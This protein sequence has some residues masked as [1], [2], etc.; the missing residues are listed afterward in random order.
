MEKIVI[1]SGEVGKLEQLAGKPQALVQLIAKNYDHPGLESLAAVLTQHGAAVAELDMSLAFPHHPY[2][3]D[4]RAFDFAEAC[5]NL[6]SLTVG[7][8]HLNETVLLHPALERV[9]LDDCWLYTSDPLR[10]GYPDS[11][12]SKV[13]R[14]DL[15]EVNWG[16][17]E[18]D[19]LGHLAF[20]PDS[21][22]QEF[23][24]YGDEDNMEI[25]PE[26]ITFDGCPHLNDVG[27]HVCGGWFVEFKGDLPALSD[28]GISSQRYGDHRFSFDEIGAGSS[29]YALR[30]RD[31]QG[32]FSGKKFLFAGEFRLLNLEKTHHIITQLGGEVVDTPSSEV[33]FAV[34]SDDEYAAYE[35]GTPSPL[36]AELVALV[37]QGAGIDIVDDSTFRGDIIY[38]WY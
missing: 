14:L 25:Y 27:I 29:A 5:P 10:L 30:L 12:A 32:S 9:R 15:Q 21:V 2:T 24:Y 33:A 28:V 4:L 1:P 37:E 16:N 3:H 18:E 31:R 38:S 20:G 34:L 36:V 11:P 8:C 6:V 7:R 22:L 23:I 26:M 19:Y 35:A 13:M 17:L